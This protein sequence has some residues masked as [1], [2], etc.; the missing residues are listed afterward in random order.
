MGYGR[1]T[2]NHEKQDAWIQGVKRLFCYKCFVTGKIDKLESHHLIGWKE[3][4]TRYEIANGVVLHHSVHA[5]FHNKYGR[6]DNTPAQF[7]EYCK[8]IHNI[9]EFPWRQGNHKPI[10]SLIEEETILKKHRNTRANQFGELVK[11]RGHEITE[12]VYSSN[13]LVTRVCLKYVV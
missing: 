7:E 8:N 6:G 3:E 9:T 10:F 2:Y 1:R 11:K 4:A 12:G 13:I 5:D